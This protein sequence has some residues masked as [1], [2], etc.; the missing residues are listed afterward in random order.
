M[1]RFLLASAAAF[2]LVAGVASAQSPPFDATNSTQPNVST[3]GPAGTY[4]MSKT[5]KTIDGRGGE[6]DKTETFDKS[7]TY[8]SGDG[9]LSAKTSIKRTDST[10]TITPPAPASTS[11][12]TTTTEESRP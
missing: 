5:Q 10:M 8:S 3:S 12:T 9:E 4:D 11:R 6:T 2:A 1:T 7:Q